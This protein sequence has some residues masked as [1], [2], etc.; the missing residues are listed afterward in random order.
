MQ[1]VWGELLIQLGDQV[2]QSYEDAQDQPDQDN[3]QPYQ[4]VQY[5]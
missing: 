5:G 2:T 3:N 1:E 4:Q